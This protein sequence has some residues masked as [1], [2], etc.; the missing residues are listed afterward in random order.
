VRRNGS[1]ALPVTQ[2]QFDRERDGW[3]AIVDV[4]STVA[5]VDDAS[6]YP[7][8]V[9]VGVDARLRLQR[10][11]KPLVVSA[12]SFVVLLGVVTGIVE[13]SSA[14]V[15]SGV[16]FG[17]I[18]AIPPFFTLRW[19]R[20][21]N[22][23]DLT[24]TPPGTLYAGVGWL[25]VAPTAGA[26]PIDATWLAERVSAELVLDDRTLRFAPLT[27]G[28]TDPGTELVLAWAA[29]AT[30]ELSVVERRSPNEELHLDTVSGYRISWRPN[31]PEPLGRI[32]IELRGT[33]QS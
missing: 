22:R 31:R 10:R 3:R 16:F 24:G 20:R 14:A 26:D 2:E 11:A 9:L 6:A 12:I 32:L 21:R 25:A 13:H 15:A 1:L 28:V 27:A 17:L 33:A 4:A 8:F 30:V 7:A 19:T 5:R 29:L 23:V 18:A